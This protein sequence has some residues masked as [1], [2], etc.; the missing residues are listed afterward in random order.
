MGLEGGFR[1]EAFLFEVMVEDQKG[2]EEIVGF[3]VVEE[4]AVGIGGDVVQEAVEVVG[5]SFDSLGQGE[6][7]VWI[8]AFENVVI[9]HPF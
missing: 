2:G 5:G 6:I 9:D 7:E 1:L 4:S 8:V 3:D